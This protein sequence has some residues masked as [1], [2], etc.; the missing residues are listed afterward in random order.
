MKRTLLTRTATTAALLTA[1]TAAVVGGTVTSASAGSCTN[2]SGIQY[3]GGVTNSPASPRA[4]PLQYTLNWTTSGTP[5]SSG[6]LAPGR[7]TGGNN[8]GID[9][10]GYYIPSGCVG[11]GGTGNGQTSGWYKINDFTQ[12]T[13]TLYC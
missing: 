12:P 6:S 3:C 2:G 11:Y 10:D 1:A 13:I 8:T 5:V 4:K 7:G 9:V